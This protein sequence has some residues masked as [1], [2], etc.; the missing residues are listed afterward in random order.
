VSIHHFDPAVE[1]GRL[2]DKRL[3]SGLSFP[4]LSLWGSYEGYPGP[5][6]IWIILKKPAD[7]P[8]WQ[9]RLKIALT[10]KGGISPE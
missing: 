7:S 1:G 5:F 8:P 10:F 9:P 3:R 6:N 2:G 4:N